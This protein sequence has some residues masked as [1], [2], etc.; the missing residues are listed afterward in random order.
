[1]VD[2]LAEK[3]KDNPDDRDG[4]LRL[5]RAEMA[6]GQPV[7]SSYQVRL[8]RIGG[9]YVGGATSTGGGTETVG[10]GVYTGREMA[11]ALAPRVACICARVAAASYFAFSNWHDSTAFLSSRQSA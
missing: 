11:A 8:S 7:V 10:G 6:L 1:M 2:G 3:L 4:W 5:A 9:M